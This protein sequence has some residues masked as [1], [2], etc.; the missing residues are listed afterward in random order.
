MYKKQA[1]E[2]G[3]APQLAKKHFPYPHNGKYAWTLDKHICTYYGANRHQHWGCP[4]KRA[5]IANQIE[6]HDNHGHNNQAPSPG[7]TYGKGHSRRPRKPKVRQPQA[8]KAPTPKG[9]NRASC[10]NNVKT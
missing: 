9:S 4:K 1:L 8:V 2:R 10:S 5:F 3:K 7:F 6:Y